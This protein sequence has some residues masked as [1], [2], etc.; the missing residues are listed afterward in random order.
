[1]KNLLLIL[2]APILFSC[3]DNDKLIRKR[4]NTNKIVIEWY[5]YSYISNSSPDFIDVKVNDSVY[6]LIKAEGIITDVYIN[7]KDIII[8]LHEPKSG[9]LYSKNIPSKF[10]DYT[11]K[12][13]S[14]ANINEVL[15]IPRGSKY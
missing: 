12:I 13:D 3:D 9:I 5:Y 15:S 1:M 10:Y 6:N 14:T 2:L 4:I 11:I 7:G 8:E